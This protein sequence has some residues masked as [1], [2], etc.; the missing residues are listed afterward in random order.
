MAPV[1]SSPPPAA[2]SRGAGP[3]AEGGPAEAEAGGA[4]GGGAGELSSLQLPPE[5]PLSAEPRGPGLA[6]EPASGGGEPQPQRRAAGPPPHLQPGAGSVCRHQL[7][8][9]QQRKSPSL[10]GWPRCRL[11]SRDPPG[12]FR[13]VWF[14]LCLSP[15]LQPTRTSLLCLGLGEVASTIQGI[16]PSCLSRPL[17]ECPG[18]NPLP[19]AALEGSQG[20]GLP[21][22][23]HLSGAR[24]AQPRMPWLGPG[25]E[26]GGRGGGRFHHQRGPGPHT[27]QHLRP[28]CPLGRHSRPGSCLP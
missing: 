22:L 21:L 12:K 8:Q 13:S 17:A 10:P 9:C 5:D 2:G 1:H 14:L 25:V 26:R 20:E 23:T 6:S 24:R 27:L 7:S 16:Q 11:T 3:A 19:C 28:F 15:M 4:G 18:G